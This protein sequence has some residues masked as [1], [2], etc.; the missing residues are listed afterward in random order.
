MERWG[1]EA[2]LDRTPGP[3]G[4][5]GRGDTAAGRTVLLAEASIGRIDRHTHA[6]G[7]VHLHYETISM[8]VSVNASGRTSTQPGP[9]D[10]LHRKRHTGRLAVHA[11]IHQLE[12]DHSYRSY[13]R[14][15]CRMTADAVDILA[16]HGL[17]AHSLDCG[18]TARLVE[19]SPG[20]L[21]GGRCS[22]E[23]IDCI[24]PTW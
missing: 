6:P 4:Y 7:R 2:H 9:E 10:C 1:P 16:G 12:E 19:G 22:E 17:A 18:R 11:G 14:R 5:L 21:A 13:R 15:E 23:G 3:V 20:R 8:G 24:G